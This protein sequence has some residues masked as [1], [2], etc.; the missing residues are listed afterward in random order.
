MPTITSPTRHG[1][2]PYAGPIGPR[3]KRQGQDVPER[4]PETAALEETARRIFS[5][6]A[7]T[8][9]GQLLAFTAAAVPAIRELRGRL[10]ELEAFDARLDREVA[11]KL[12]ALDERSAPLS[13]TEHAEALAIATRISDSPTLRGE[14]TQ[15]ISAGNPRGARL[16]RLLT[17]LDPLVSGVSEQQLQTWRD[18]AAPSL[19]QEESDHYQTA[20]Y[21]AMR[22]RQP[23]DAP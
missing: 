4:F 10:A 20:K 12:Q 7:L 1:F 22:E 5:D 16:A 8:I 6:E 17:G 23:W 3:F 14:V 2:T 18:L 15:A 21:N 19:P 11:E 9:R 13:A